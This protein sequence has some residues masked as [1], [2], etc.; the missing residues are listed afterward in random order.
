MLYMRNENEPRWV[1]ILIIYQ[2]KNL[3]C[4][5]LIDMLLYIVE[6]DAQPKDS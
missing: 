4:L 2:V 5:L 6:Q 1:V 3:G